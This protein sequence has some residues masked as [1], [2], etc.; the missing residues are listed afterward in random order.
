M[1]LVEEPYAAF[2]AE[3]FEIGLDPQKATK[4]VLTQSFGSFILIDPACI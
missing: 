3:T 1:L 2:T 4:L